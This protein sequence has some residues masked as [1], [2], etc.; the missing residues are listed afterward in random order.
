M[1][2]LIKDFTLFQDI[3]T[4]VIAGLIATGLLALGIFFKDLPRKILIRYYEKQNE[5]NILKI[6]KLR[7]IMR[8][9]RDETGALYVHVIKY[10]DTGKAI[11]PHSVLKETVLWE[12][13]NKR[14]NTCPLNTNKDY[15]VKRLQDIWFERTVLGNWIDMVCDVVQHK[16]A[17]ISVRKKDL[18]SYGQS[19]FDAYHIEMFRTR[20]LKGKYSGFYTLGLSFCKHKLPD[21]TVAGYIITAAE[22]I[23]KLL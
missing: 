20:Y 18:D 23:K 14:C 6:A 9:L 7:R 5:K 16:E 22:E 1:D 21:M 11:T 17:I 15:E 13:V 4:N 10:S 2:K 8:R 3:T 19:V 12:E